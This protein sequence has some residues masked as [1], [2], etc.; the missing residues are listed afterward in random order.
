MSCSPRSASRLSDAQQD[1]LKKTRIAETLPRT[2][3]EV[4]AWIERELV[5]V[6]R[7]AAST[8]YGSQAKSGVVQAGP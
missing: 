8:W 6:D 2:T 7:I 4:G 5:G 1:E 3:L